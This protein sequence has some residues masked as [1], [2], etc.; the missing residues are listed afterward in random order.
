MPQAG[1]V[2]HSGLLPTEPTAAAETH[3]PAALASR[4]AS[5]AATKPHTTPHRHA[6][7]GAI[8]PAANKVVIAAAA[9]PAESA[10][11]AVG[12]GGQPAKGTGAPL[13]TP[14]AG[15]SHA[16]GLPA[17]APA[18]Q[19]GHGQTGASPG[20]AV[21][22]RDPQPRPPG[23]TAGADNAPRPPGPSAAAE[24][25]GDAGARAEAQAPRAPT[26]PAPPAASVPQAASVPGQ[27]HDRPTKPGASEGTQPDGN[28]ARPPLLCCGASTGGTARAGSSAEKLGAQQDSSNAAVTTAP[29]AT[30]S[31]AE[32]GASSALICDTTIRLTLL[33]RLAG[34]TLDTDTALRVLKT[35]SQWPLES[36]VADAQLIKQAL[37]QTRK[38]MQRGKAPRFAPVPRSVKTKRARIGGAPKPG[39]RN[40]PRNVA[41][42]AAGASTDGATEPDGAAACESGAAPLLT[43]ANLARLP[44]EP[45]I[46][47]GDKRRRTEHEGAY[48][49][50]FITVGAPS[51]CVRQNVQPAQ[52][53]LRACLALPRSWP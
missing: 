21:P 17:A 39:G 52:P 40:S 25:A 2:G 22:H 30:A 15:S 16:R 44:L 27:Q 46:K 28:R 41:A 20:A 13:A 42:A 26:A 9:A 10:G 24:G 23:G 7:H 35:H 12:P 33:Q 43:R 11:S 4:S 14:A 53:V 50:T 31:G 38:T 32:A 47:P 3:E 29:A 36:A 34:G 18:G 48:R 6:R 1:G 8:L 51:Q 19:Q 37:A 5:K 49:A 45:L